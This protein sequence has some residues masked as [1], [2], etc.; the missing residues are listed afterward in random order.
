MKLLSQKPQ[1]NIMS[2]S[3]RAAKQAA[4][5][6][7]WSSGSPRRTFKPVARGE[8]EE[9]E[10]GRSRVVEEEEGEEGRGGG[11]RGGEE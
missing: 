5:E 9:E 7:L 6:T 10:E 1:T 4:G 8:E 3:G 11:G 2:L